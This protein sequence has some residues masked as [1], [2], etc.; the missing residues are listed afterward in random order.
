[1]NGRLKLEVFENPHSL[2]DGPQSVKAGPTGGILT[3]AP[4]YF[5]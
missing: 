2:A 4:T 3:V 5:S 1:M